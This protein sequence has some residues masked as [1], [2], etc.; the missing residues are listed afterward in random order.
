MSEHLLDVI[1]LGIRIGYFY[2]TERVFR[3]EYCEFAVAALGGTER[4]LPVTPFNPLS[5]PFPPYL[6]TNVT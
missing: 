5:A 2:S 1:L 3:Q 6:Y 4:V